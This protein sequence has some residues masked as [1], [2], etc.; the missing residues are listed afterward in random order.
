MTGFL[1]AVSVRA[2]LALL[3]G[4]ATASLL[5]V[6]AAGAFG[7]RHLGERTHSIVDRDFAAVRSLGELRAQV[8]NLRRY[9]KDMFLNMGDETALDRYQ[10]SWRKEADA[11]QAELARLGGKLDDSQ[12]DAV[13]R[14]GDGLK[15]Y[16]AG[17]EAVV[18]DIRTGKVNDPW[19][20]NQAMEAHKSAVRAADKA[21][22]EIASHVARSV[23]SQR[24]QLESIERNA[25]AWTLGIS[26][27]VLLG[28]LAFAW[29]IATGIAVPL[30][31]AAEAIE[32]VARGDLSGR[33]QAAGSDEIGRLLVAISAMQER[34]A[35]MLGG[36]RDGIS[37]VATASAQI[38]QG[39][40]DLSQR[41]EQQAASVQ[42]SA[43]SMEQLTGTVRQTADH[44]RQAHRLAGE[45]SGVAERG[46]A[47]VAEVVQT[48]DQI[49]QAS[50]R[51][52]DIIGVIDGIAFQT[53]I[54]ALNA[55]VEAARAGEQG[56]GFAVV[57]GEVRALAQRSAEAARQIKTLIGDSVQRVDSGSALVQSAGR[58]MDEIV[59]QVQ[60]VRERIDLITRAA[61]EQAAGIEQIGQSVG[62]LDG[63]T[64]QNAALVEQSAAA[65][66]SLR[67]QAQRLAEAVSA[68]RVG[69]SSA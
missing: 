41:T 10:A 31:R 18:A 59:A 14:M 12:R 56:R 27:A 66:A 29:K 33:V 54:L 49:Q 40:A 67:Q 26:A 47:V 63:M 62:T 15:G 53:N 43:S 39:S 16:R 52:A 58:T 69:A 9:E 64:Q 51:I 68:F 5:L 37:T 38:A 13:G 45:A 1:S 20:A 7:A 57:A 17:V 3:V 50:R 2:K 42:Q 21:L 4:A 55:A 32:R 28:V 46:G 11:A 19:A 48:M 36:V 22:G 34:L 24:Q 35:Q 8:G 60:S 30:G 44:A 65:A 6:V 25:L 23:D 61:D